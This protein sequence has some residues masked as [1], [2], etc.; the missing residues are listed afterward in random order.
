[1]LAE[2][3]CRVKFDEDRPRSSTLQPTVPKLSTESALAMVLLL[4]T[5]ACRSGGFRDG[6]FAKDGVRYAI[7]PPQGWTAVSV[8]DTDL[9]WASGRTGFSIAVNSTCAQSADVPLNVLTN[10]LLMGFT[11]RQRVSETSETLDGREA[12]RSRF[13]ARLD[14]VP[15][16]LE[17]LVLKKDGCVYDFMYLA[18][19][20]KQGEHQ[21]D[22]DHVVGAFKTEPAA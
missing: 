2:Q 5:G 22:F 17:L 13:K 16:S 9:A 14:G 21:D 4:A 18:P 8:E 7:Q 1:M 19:P 11:E 10:Q 20:D 12:L 6:V 3:A 15:V